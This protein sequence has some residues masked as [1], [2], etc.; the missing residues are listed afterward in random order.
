MKIYFTV[1]CRSKVCQ[2]EAAMSDDVNTQSGGGGWTKLHRAALAGQYEEVRR[3]VERGADVNI[4]TKFGWTA[5]MLAAW[6][7]HGDIVEYLHQAGAADIN[8]KAKGGYTAV[9]VA[10]YSGH[11]DIVQY[12]HAAGADINIGNIYGSTTV[13]YVAHAYAYE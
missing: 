10:A 9:M 11:G 2:G 5:V 8:I 4:K 1:F 12:L 7:G 13:M 3:L 6:G